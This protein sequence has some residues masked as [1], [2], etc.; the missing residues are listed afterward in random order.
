MAVSIIAFHIA[1]PGLDPG[2]HIFILKHPNEKTWMS[3]SSPATGL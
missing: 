2:V 1:S 3:G